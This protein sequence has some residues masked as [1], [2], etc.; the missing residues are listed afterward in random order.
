MNNIRERDLGGA[1]ALNEVRIQIL[2]F[3]TEFE[4]W[5]VCQVQ[6]NWFCQP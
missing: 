2:H 6:H 1:K 4:V 5:L 3:L